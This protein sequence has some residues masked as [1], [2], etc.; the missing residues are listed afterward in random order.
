MKYNRPVK[1][2]VPCPQWLSS[3]TSGRSWGENG[4]QVHMEKGCKMET[5]EIIITII[6][7][8]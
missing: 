7:D 5:L 8:E 2:P 6:N 3:E 1:E 4:Y